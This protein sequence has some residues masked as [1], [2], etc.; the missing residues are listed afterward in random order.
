MLLRVGGFGRLLTTEETPLI[1]L[2]PLARRQLGEGFVGV[3]ADKLSESFPWKLLWTIKNS[4]STRI[5]R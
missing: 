5:G 4:F 2:Y 3:R 1:P